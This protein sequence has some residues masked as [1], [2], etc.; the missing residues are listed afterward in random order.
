M[1]DEEIWEAKRDSCEFLLDSAPPDGKEC[2]F[3]DKQHVFQGCSTHERCPILK[4]WKQEMENKNTCY[5]PS[6]L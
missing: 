6:F 4:V 2:V 5:Q 1:T 3:P